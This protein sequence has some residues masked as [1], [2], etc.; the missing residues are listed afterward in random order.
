MAVADTSIEAYQLKK[1][2]L[3]GEKLLVYEAIKK[4]GP[5]NNRQLLEHLGRPFEMGSVSARVNKLVELG[6]VVLAYKAVSTTG[7]RVQFWCTKSAMRQGNL[8]GLPE[9]DS[10]N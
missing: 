2:E 8:L 7:R 4:L 9:Q 5:V 3:T 6:W 10:T 1:P